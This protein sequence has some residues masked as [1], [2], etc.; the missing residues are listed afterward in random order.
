[1][2]LSRSSPCLEAL[3]CFQDCVTIPFVFPHKPSSLRGS[4][5]P[6]CY[7]AVCNFAFAYDTP[8]SEQY[9]YHGQSGVNHL[10]TVWWEGDWKRTIA[11]Q[12]I[13]SISSLIFTGMHSHL[14]DMFIGT[15]F[16]V[17][18]S[19]CGHGLNAFGHYI[20]QAAAKCQIRV[21]LGWNSPS[22]KSPS[23]VTKTD[24]LK[25]LQATVCIL[26]PYISS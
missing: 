22:I 6:C 9:K 25:S 17:K 1:V 10:G 24:F 11:L 26:A 15:S 23:S 2:L 14:N 18:E 5:H 4:S 20:L 7:N 8:W 16:A 13:H 19:Y 3:P 21:E 12:V